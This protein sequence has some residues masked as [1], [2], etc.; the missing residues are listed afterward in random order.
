MTND[1]Y[2]KL[3]WMP[4]DAAVIMSPPGDHDLPE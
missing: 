1:L 4:S 3:Q 2:Q